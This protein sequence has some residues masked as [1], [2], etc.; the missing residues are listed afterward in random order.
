L[1]KKKTYTMTFKRV[2]ILTCK[3]TVTQKNVLPLKAFN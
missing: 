2:A 1:D 3:K